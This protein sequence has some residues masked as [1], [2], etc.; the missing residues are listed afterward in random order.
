MVGALGEPGG[1]SA[2][3]TLALAYSASSNLV[4]ANVALTHSALAV[5]ALANSVLPI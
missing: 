5:L 2:L 4:L 1:R 3:A